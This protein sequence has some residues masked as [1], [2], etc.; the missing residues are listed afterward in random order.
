M[1]RIIKR[2]L[3]WAS[4]VTA[5]VILSFIGLIAWPDLF[6][7]H[8]LSAGKIVVAS[9]R[10]IPVA[11]GQRLLHDCERLLERSPLMAEGRQYHLY[12]TNQDW[13][14]RLFFLLRPDAGGIE[15]YFGF[16]GN[17]FLSGANFETGRHVKWSYVATP[18]RTLAYFCAHE[19]THIVIDE[20]IGLVGKLR[21]AEWVHEGFPDYVAVE[22]RQSFEQLRSAL[23]DR[24]VD[25][26]MMQT[27]GSYPKYRL[28]VTYF[29][30]KQGWSVEQLLKTSLSMDEAMTIM[31]ADEKR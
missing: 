19:L 24:P 20:H 29:I 7:A 21:L 28:L 2:A 8:S 11:G 4:A 30:E 12:V 6:F 1:L 27:Y 17:A 5:A 15:Y 9:D 26:T 14:H 3:L 13:R 22:N 16:R 23:G 10:P 18:P 25:V 31:R